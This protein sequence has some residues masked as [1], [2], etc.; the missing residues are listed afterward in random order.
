V[1]KTERLVNQFFWRFKPAKQAAAQSWSGGEGETPDQVSSDIKPVKFHGL[2][3]CGGQF[4]AG[5]E[6][7]RPIRIRRAKG[8]GFILSVR[9]STL[10][11]FVRVGM[12]NETAKQAIEL[13][14]KKE[15]L[16]QAFSEG[17]VF[18]D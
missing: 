2:F 16:L 1:H 8:K 5:R 17:G 3:Y 11:I 7:H 14:W 6:P 10:A 12:G 18:P 9:K 4:K 15:A 13:A